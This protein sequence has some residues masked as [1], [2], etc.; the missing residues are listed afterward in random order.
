LV[1]R[2]HQRTNLALPAEGGGLD[3]QPLSVFVVAAARRGAA[4]LVERSQLERRAA[5][6]LGGAGVLARDP[7][8]HRVVLLELLDD[9]GAR[10]VQARVVRD[11]VL[12]YRRT[13]LFEP[14]EFLQ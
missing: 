11:L 7:G 13:E 10:R 8:R 12:D 14:R 2:Q 4:G 5:R 6:V 1:A 9:A 3:R